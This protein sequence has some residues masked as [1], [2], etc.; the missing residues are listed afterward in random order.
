[1]WLQ[2]NA[3]NISLLT[4]KGEGRRGVSNSLPYHVKV[5]CGGDY[6]RLVPPVY[7]RSVLGPSGTDRSKKVFILIADYE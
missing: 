4:E 1:M 7:D 2:V 3:S 5:V 6:S